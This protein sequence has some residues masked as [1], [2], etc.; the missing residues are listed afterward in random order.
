MPSVCVNILRMIFIN[1][2]CSLGKMND[3][4]IQA[5]AKVDFPA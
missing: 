4:Y 3:C 2:Y 5:L 1:Y